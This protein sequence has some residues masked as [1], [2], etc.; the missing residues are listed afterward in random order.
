MT[1][2]DPKGLPVVQ[3]ALINEATAA[4]YE[5]ILNEEFDELHRAKVAIGVLY[6]F[7]LEDRKIPNTSDDVGEVLNHGRCVK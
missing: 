4:L 2:I 3:A 6:H 7:V 5:Y 1:T